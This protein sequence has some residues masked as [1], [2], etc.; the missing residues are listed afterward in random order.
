[1]RPLFRT[2]LFFPL[3]YFRRNSPCSVFLC[4]FFSKCF[5]FHCRGASL[6]LHLHFVDDFW[7]TQGR[8]ASNNKNNNSRRRTD[9]L[10]DYGC[11]IILTFFYSLLLLLFWGCAKFAEAGLMNEKPATTITQTAAA[12]ATTAERHKA[13]K[14]CRIVSLSCGACKKII[15]KKL[16]LL[17]NTKSDSAVDAAVAVRRLLCCSVVHSCFV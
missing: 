9:W 12:A 6:F 17:F 1:M 3:R 7:V 16:L 4:T 14:T 10:S 15:M 8:T 11:K 2:L 13:K 5:H